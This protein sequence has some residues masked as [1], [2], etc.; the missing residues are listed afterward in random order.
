M[1][2]NDWAATVAIPFGGTFAK[3]LSELLNESPRGSA[4]ALR[5]VGATR[6]Q[7]ILSAVFPAAFSRF[8]LFF[9]CRWETC[10]REASRAQHKEK[11]RSGLRTASA[12]P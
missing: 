4:L 7:I 6:R 3:V 11:L 5:G 12:Q 1:V 8:L 2:G 10:V 9:F